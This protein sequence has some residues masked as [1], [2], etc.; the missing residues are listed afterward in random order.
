MR[1]ELYVS[2]VDEKLKFQLSY[3]IFT[4]PIK[5]KKT[6]LIIITNVYMFYLCI[7]YIYANYIYMS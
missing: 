3:S 7:M 1:D 2:S 4:F 6:I 5:Y